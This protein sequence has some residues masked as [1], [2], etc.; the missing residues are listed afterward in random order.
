M[1]FRHIWIIIHVLSIANYSAQSIITC[2]WLPTSEWEEEINV[3][4]QYTKTTLLVEHQTIISHAMPGPLHI[5]KEIIYIIFFIF[6][7]IYTLFHRSFLAKWCHWMQNMSKYI[8]TL[9]AHDKEPSLHMSY[10]IHITHKI[11]IQL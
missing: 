4:C 5:I 2:P 9:T 6:I 10:I 7:F 8:N 3:Q 11:T 1:H